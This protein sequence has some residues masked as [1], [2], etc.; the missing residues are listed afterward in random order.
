MAT[1]I[2]WIWARTVTCPNPACGIETPLVSKWWLG[3]KKGK[4]A[5]IVPKVV[6]DHVEYSIGHDPKRAPTKQ[7]DGTI[8]GRRGAL[9]VA[10]GSVISM[11]EIRAQGKK[12]KIGSAMTAVVCEGGRKREYKAP[13]DEDRLEVQFDR[14]NQ[15]NMGVLADNPRYMSPPLYGMDTFDKL[16]TARQLT[17]LTTFSD[18]VSEAREQVLREGL[19]D[20]S[21][22]LCFKLYNAQ[23]NQLLSQACSPPFMVAPPMQSALEPPQLIQP[24][25]GSELPP[26]QKQTVQFTWTMPPG[27]PATT[28]YMIKIIELNDRYANYRELIDAYPESAYGQ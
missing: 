26:E 28:Q 14:V 4:E 9:C 11:E 7:N 19:P 15:L 3:K 5:Y 6:G 20:G 10:C 21:Y 1:V 2:A 23:R 17:A 27:A 13:M 22:R 24:Y 25:D 16:F 18:L 8:S 12:G